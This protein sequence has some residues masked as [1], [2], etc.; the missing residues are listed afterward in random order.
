MPNK[1]LI[2]KMKK[3]FIL[4]IFGIFLIGCKSSSTTHAKKDHQTTIRVLLDL[5]NVVDDRVKVI[6][7]W[8]A[9]TPEN[10]RF[11]MPKIIPGTY[12][13]NDYGTFINDLRAKD[14]QYNELNLQK[15]NNNEWL[16]QKTKNLHKISYW[17]HDTFDVEGNHNIFSPAGSNIQKNKNFVLNLFAIVGYFDFLKNAAYDITIKYPSFLKPATSQKQYD[18][19]YFQKIDRSQKTKTDRYYF[20]NYKELADTP[21]MYAEPN[22]IRFTENHMNIQ[23]SVYSPNKIVKASSLE[24]QLRRMIRAQTHFLEDFDTVNE[25]NILLYLADT[26]DDASGFGALEHKES[27]LVVLPEALSIKQLK[28]Y[29]TNTISHEFFHII[30]PIQIHSEEIENFNFNNPSMSQHLWLYEGTTE[31]FSMLFQI[32]EALTTRKEFFE[33][34]IDKMIEAESFNDQIPFAELSKNIL[35]SPYKENFLNVYHKGALLSM[36]MDLIILENSEGK[37][38]ILDLIKDLSVKFGKNNPFQDDMLIAEIA[39]L[40]YP[41]VAAFI[42]N[43]IIDNKPVDYIFYL[44]KAGVQYTTREIPSEYFRHHQDAFIQASEINDQITFTASSKYSSFLQKLGIQKNDV[45]LEINQKKYTTKNIYDLFSDS[46]QWKN[47]NPIEF[48][49]K[50]EGEKII[51]NSIVTSPTFSKPILKEKP[52]ASEKEKRI[53]KKWIND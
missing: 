13:V 49:I 30:T 27:T 38:G 35:S 12:A 37:K 8:E 32:Q 53:L 23:L 3:Y 19:V 11:Y 47:G 10:I 24:P 39:T 29:L 42:N 46:K 1:V 50:R 18:K 41:E 6:L 31:Y 22:T 17:V 4:T 28:E 43:H 26:E 21:I 36:C 25:Y 20:K 5:V 40:G 44:N 45:L 9:D 48:I 34:I 33:E 16:I 2:L 14:D 52:D 7:Q 15:E 51:L